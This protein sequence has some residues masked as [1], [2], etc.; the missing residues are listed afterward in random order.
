MVTAR[1][2]YSPV[3]FD[4]RFKLFHEL[5]SRKVREILLISTPYDAW[6]MEEDCRLSKPSTT[7]TGA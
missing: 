6:V 7:S 1:P 2:N 3:Q 5:M 4:P